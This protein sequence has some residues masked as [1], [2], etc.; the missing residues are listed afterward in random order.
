MTQLTRDERCHACGNL[1]VLPVLAFGVI[2]PSDADYVC[3]K[4]TAPPRPDD[5][6]FE[7][8]R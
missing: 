3:V 7:D 8:D 2:V 1:L 6:A 4:L 5:G